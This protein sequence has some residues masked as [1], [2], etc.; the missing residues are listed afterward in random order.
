MRLNVE[1]HVYHIPERLREIDP[2]LSVKF[3]TDTQLYEVWGEDIASSPYVLGRFSALDARVVYAV[4]ESYVIAERTGNPYKEI[5]KQF[6]RND[7]QREREY[8]NQLWEKEYRSRDILKYSDTP[9]IT[10]GI[11][12]K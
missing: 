9:V 8:W 4:R 5:L 2:K 7:E 11:D 1:T 10:P 6:D 3:N 12:V